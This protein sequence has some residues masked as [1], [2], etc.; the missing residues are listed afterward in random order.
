MTD[1]VRVKEIL[2]V[3]DTEVIR[4][5]L[6][7]LLETEGY[8]V[9][10][11]ADGVE[12]LEMIKEKEYDLVFCDIHMPRKNGFD[13][14]KES[15]DIAPGL[16]FIMTDSLPDQLAESAQEAGAVTCITKPFDIDDIRDCVSRAEQRKVKG[17]DVPGRN[18]RRQED[19]APRS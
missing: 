13:T 4:N 6:K 8:I 9:S 7:D 15:R 14:F 16:P 19:K 11:A 3:D 18:H 17:D 10:C 2:I 12:A 5:L 1:S